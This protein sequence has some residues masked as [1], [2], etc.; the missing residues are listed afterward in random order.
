MQMLKE[1]LIL[2]YKH[3]GNVIFECYLNFS[4]TSKMLNLQLKSFRL[5]KN[6]KHPMNQL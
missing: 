1:H 2:L 6:K 5:K 3:Y 4:E